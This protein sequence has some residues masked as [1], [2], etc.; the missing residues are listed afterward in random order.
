MRT[1]ELHLFNDEFEDELK[2]FT[3]PDDQERFTAL[4]E[5]V[6]TVT[7]GQYRVVI[8][9]HGSPVGFFLLHRTERVQVY[10][11]NPKSMLLTSFSI[12]H[13]HQGKG[14]AKMGMLELERFILSNFPNCDEIVLAVNH[15]NLPAQQLYKHVGFIDTGRRKIGDIGEQ[16]I[17]ELR[18]KV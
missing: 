12:N 9:K 2:S 3:L 4:P 18:I 14:Y 10:S 11:N 15:K 6:L 1:V 7:E 5:K 16:F 13:K 17:M 8:L